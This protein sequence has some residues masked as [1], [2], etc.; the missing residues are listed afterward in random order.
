MT[1]ESS[2]IKTF[3]G[4]SEKQ[5]LKARAKYGSW[6]KVA[7]FFNI[8]KQTIRAIADN[9][10]IDT[11]KIIK[12]KPK[13]VVKPKFRP[14][15]TKAAKRILKKIDKAKAVKAAKKLVKTLK[16][17]KERHY[18]LIF[19]ARFL[20][21]RS[22]KP[23]AE[24]TGYSLGRRKKGFPS[25]KEQ[26]KMREEAIGSIIRDKLEG[27]SE[28]FPI[29]NTVKVEVYEYDPVEKGKQLQTAKAI[30]A[31]N[32]AKARRKERR[33]ALIKELKELDNE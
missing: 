16:Y 28:C 17:R 20:C 8:R 24:L 31:A 6:E 21:P 18:Q 27:D 26:E 30:A 15:L 22:E 4:I 19:K 25:L 5:I 29:E 11:A 33:S 3:A 7:Q 2:S 13:R 10:G 12:I 14:R 32:M 9:F 23:T 1:I